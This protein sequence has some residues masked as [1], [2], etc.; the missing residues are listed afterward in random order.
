[1]TTRSAELAG[2]LGTDWRWLQPAAE[3]A[4]MTSG[5]WAAGLSPAR[6]QWG[7]LPRVA[8]RTPE[9]APQSVTT[10]RSFTLRTMARWGIADS[11]YDVA[12]VVSE[13]LTNALRHALADDAGP[14]WPDGPGRIRLGLLQAGHGVLCAVADPS[15]RAPMLSR[16]DLLAESGRG[17]QLVASLSDDWGYCAT[18]HQHGKVVWATFITT[19]RPQPDLDL[20][21][22]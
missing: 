16:P 10:A 22:T 7:S 21:P 2:A 4:S 12:S 15:Q 19:R 6:P 8:T 20:G 3:M 9:L 1:M 14:V 5:T 17:L 18:P 13:L 11:S